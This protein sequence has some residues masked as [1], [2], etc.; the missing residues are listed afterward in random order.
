MIRVHE[1]LISSYGQV[2][3][4][5]RPN[6]L[7]RGIVM[8]VYWSALSDRM[9]GR[10]NWGGGGARRGGREVGRKKNVFRRIISHD[11][12]GIEKGRQGKGEEN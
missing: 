12:G 2:A 6:E 10:A 8:E 4:S 7:R 1:Y 9:G 3:P 11:H 5:G